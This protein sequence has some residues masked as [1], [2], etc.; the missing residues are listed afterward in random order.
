MPDPQRQNMQQLADSWLSQVVADVAR[1]R[2]LDP[3][4]VQQTIDRAPLSA[5]EGKQAGLI[6]VLAY[7]DAVDQGISDTRDQDHAISLANYVKRVPAPSKADATIATI[8]GT[9]PVV[10]S[11]SDADPFRGSVTMGA[12]TLRA[13]FDDAIA[14]HVSAIILRIDSPGG[15]Y[16]A[17]D[18]IW[19]SVGRARSANIPVIVS[20]SGVA[21]SGGYFVAA[22]ATKIV[23]E[24]G[25]ITGSIG[26]FGGKIVV[27]GLLKNLSVGVDGISAGAQADIDSAVKDFS[28]GEWQNLQHTLDVI[29][30]DF[31]GKVA[32]GRHLDPAKT[33]QIAQGQIWTGAD[34][35][36]KGLVDAL[37]GWSVALDLARNEAGIKKDQQVA[38]AVYPSNKQQAGRFI[39]Q[40]LRRGVMHSAI[41]LGPLQRWATRLGL[42][43]VLAED[44]STDHHL[45]EVALPPLMVNGVPQ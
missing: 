22:P 19:R 29:Y 2:K 8:Y 24:P 33:E 21:A 34:A 14:D 18:T 15:S 23:A 38:L 28:P 1:D 9:G 39:S 36:G 35:K 43:S 16:T 12:D 11:Q 27:D 42:T 20:M 44:G 25:T 45:P 6:D 31:T 7:R 4:V 3:Q 26:V 32:A 10:L 37:G 30:A 40:L 41:D 13:A 17:A 5:D